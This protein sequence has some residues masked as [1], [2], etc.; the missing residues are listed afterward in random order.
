MHEAGA[1]EEAAHRL[2]EHAAGAPVVAV[3]VR[4][5]PGVQV[6]EAAR[7]WRTAVEGSAVAAARVNW[8]RAYH[9]LRCP[10]CEDDYFGPASAHCPSCHANGVLIAETPLVAVTGWSA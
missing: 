1:V 10:R 3:T 9:L 5:G 2:I 4:I 6:D 8:R 7:A